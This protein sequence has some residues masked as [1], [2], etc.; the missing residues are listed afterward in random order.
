MAGREKRKRQRKQRRTGAAFEMPGAP[1]AE[2]TAPKSKDDLAREQLVPLREGERPVAVTIGAVIS[3][4]LGM[5]T[6]VLFVFGVDT[7]DADFN[8][9]GTLLYSGLMLLM[10]WGMWNARYWAVLGFQA[11]LAL[12]IVIWSLLLVKAESVLSVLVAVLIIGSA[13]TLFWFLV[14]S[15]ARIQMPD[16]RPPP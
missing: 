4:L 3:G 8:A 11:L 1:P 15:L 16:R 5:S 13:G 10:A 6:I 12:L 7:G 9:A 14:K 2:G